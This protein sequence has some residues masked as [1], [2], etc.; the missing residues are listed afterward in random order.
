MRTETEQNLKRTG[1]RDSYDPDEDFEDIP[2]EVLL[3]PPM[4]DRKR[5]KP[6]IQEP[7]PPTTHVAYS[8]TNEDTKLNESIYQRN[9]N[10]NN[11][12]STSRSSSRNRGSDISKDSY[13][14]DEDDS[15][16][17]MYVSPN[18][19]SKNHYHHH[20]DE[21]IQQRGRNSSSL[22]NE[23]KLDESIKP[24]ITT[25]TPTTPGASDDESSTAEPIKFAN[26]DEKKAFL[27]KP[28]P[29]KYGIVQCYIER[30]KQGFRGNACQYDVYLKDGKYIY[31]FPFIL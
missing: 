15:H 10:N 22:S 27:T 18:R 24:S 25:S 12:C 30:T 16:Q 17:D 23:G 11:K 9:N 19:R 7:P 21:D 28:C 14:S 1:V 29:L 6:S 3:T 13:F 26:N 5:S 8:N 2:T 20:H 4:N 31:L